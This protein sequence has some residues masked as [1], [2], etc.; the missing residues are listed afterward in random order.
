M[1]S[2]LSLAASSRKRSSSA[3]AIALGKADADEA[4]GG[5]RVAGADQLH[6]LARRRR[7]AEMDRAQRGDPLFRLALHDR[8][9]VGRPG[10][11]RAKQTT[12]PRDCHASR[13]ALTAPHQPFELLPL[14]VGRLLVGDGA[15]E[16]AGRV[17]EIDGRLVVHGVAGRG[18]DLL[19]GGTEFPGDVGDLGGG[20]GE[21]DDA[22]IEIG[23]IALQELGCVALGIDGDEDDRAACRL[24]GRV[25]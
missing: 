11:T 25:R 2:G 8:L 9:P 3:T 18:R 17:H 21:A 20:T 10:G 24:R 12:S 16:A 14:H 22:R 6:R 5:D 13:A 4:A 15:D 1:P 19:V 23:E 7:L